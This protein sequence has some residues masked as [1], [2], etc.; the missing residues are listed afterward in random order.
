MSLIAVSSESVAYKSF[1]KRKQPKKKKKI[2]NKDTNTIFAEFNSKTEKQRLLDCFFL[3]LVYKTPDYLFCV[4][5]EKEE[6]DCTDQNHPNDK[7]N[8]LILAE[9][10]LLPFFFF[11]I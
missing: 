8:L 10:I 5:E 9:I 6:E 2:K 4:Y 11:I 7:E 1:W 3:K